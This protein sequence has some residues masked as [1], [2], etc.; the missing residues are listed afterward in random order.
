MCTLQFE[1]GEEDAVKANMQKTDTLWSTPDSRVLSKPNSSRSQACYRCERSGNF[2]R[3]CRVKLPTTHRRN[4]Q[5]ENW[6]QSPNF[7]SVNLLRYSNI[8]NLTMMATVNGK[9]MQITV[10][11]S[12]VFS[13]APTV[14][15]LVEKVLLRT[16]TGQTSAAL[17]ETE[18]KIKLGQLR[19]HHGVLVANIG[20]DLV[21]EMD[22]I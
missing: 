21:V 12:M 7:V 17:G 6:K 8:D 20:D 9:N 4:E 1:E 10:D 16:V 2:R 13:I 11:T 15:P 18:V 5:Q 19:I 3:D 22:L 14:S